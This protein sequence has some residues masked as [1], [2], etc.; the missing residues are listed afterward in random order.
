MAQGSA[1]AHERQ[2]RR[3]V[4]RHRNPSRFPGNAV[5]SEVRQDHGS[6]RARVP[7]LQER[8]SGAVEE[9]TE[10][11]WLSD[12]E[13]VAINARVLALFG[14]LDGRVRDETLFQAALA[15]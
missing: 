14:G 11:T 1:G 6:S 3:Y 10:P 2:G 8:I 7:S 13:A 15:R 5:R 12:R 4:V 9:V